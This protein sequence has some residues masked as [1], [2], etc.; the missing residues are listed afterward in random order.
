MNQNV[1]R[2]SN[3]IFLSEVD[4]YSLHCE[5]KTAPSELPFGEDFPTVTASTT[6][7]GIRWSD[8]EET[9]DWAVRWGIW[10]ERGGRRRSLHPARVHAASSRW[11]KVCVLPASVLQ[12]MRSPEKTA[13]VLWHKWLWNDGLQDNDENNFDRWRLQEHHHPA[14]PSRTIWFAILSRHSS[15]REKN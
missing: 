7:F 2:A 14:F 13:N 4:R 12:F 3:W 1:Y 15:K 5:C 6:I 8:H 9:A 10:I 11:G